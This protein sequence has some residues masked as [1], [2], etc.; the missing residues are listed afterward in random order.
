MTTSFFLIALVT[1]C[2]LAPHDWN[3]VAVGAVALYAGAKLPR[4]W[5]WAVPIAG[6]IL[7]DVILDWGHAEPERAAFTVSRM[8]IYGTYIATAFLGILARRAKGW[9]APFSLG[10][11]ALV[12]SGLFFLTTNFAEWIS[13]PLNLYPHT[14]DGLIACYTAAIPFADKTV[15]ADLVG[16]GLLFGLDALA[17]RVAEG[18][19]ATRPAAEAQLVEA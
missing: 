4:R 10:A 9:S 8:T 1:V 13:G 17:H 15:V 7:S 6:M 5:A 2:R 19:R 11:L 12:G 3:L 14:W 16:T 18:R